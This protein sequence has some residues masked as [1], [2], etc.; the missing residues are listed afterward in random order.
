MSLFVLD[1]AVSQLASSAQKGTTNSVGAH[2]LKDAD[3]V[4]R[5]EA[6]YIMVI[7]KA[8]F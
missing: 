4:E 1:E 5:I 7:P 2:R 6:I 3:V 8:V